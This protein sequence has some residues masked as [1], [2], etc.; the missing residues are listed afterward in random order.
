LGRHFLLVFGAGLTLA[1]FA[2]FFSDGERAG[3]IYFET[4]YKVYRIS[5]DGLTAWIPFSLAW[6]W[7]AALLLWLVMGMLRISRQDSYRKQDEYFKI[8]PFQHE[9]PNFKQEYR[10]YSRFSYTYKTSRFKFVPTLRQEFRKY[11]SPTFSNLSEDFQFRTR[12]RLQLTVNLDK[13]KIHKISLSSEQLFSISKNHIPNS[14]TDF[15]YRESRFTL[16]YS[17]SPQKSPLIYSL[18]YMNNLVGIKQ[19]YLV[20]YFA[21][22]IIWENPFKLKQRK[23]ESI[24]EN[25]E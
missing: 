19:N 7:M 2:L 25:F 21:F 4:I 10:F 16:Y 22:D 14:W 1:G 5:W 17:F 24:T 12:L 18:G 13:N 9:N 3:R 20:N 11:Y 6:G 15:N 8:A 23:K